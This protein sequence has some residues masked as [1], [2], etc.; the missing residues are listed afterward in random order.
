MKLG[1]QQSQAKD[2]ILSWY[3]NP[4]SKPAFY[5]G[6]WAGTGKTSIAQP[7]AE[8]LAGS[9]VVYAAYTGKAAYVLQEKGCFSAGTM[10]SVIYHSG[11]ASEK[12]VKELREK[13][14]AEAVKLLSDGYDEAALD[15]HPRL[16]LLDGEIALE[17]KNARR[18]IFSLNPDSKL[19]LAKLAVIDEVS[20]VNEKMA[21]DW[22]SFGVKTLV[23]GDP[24][25]LPPVAGEGFFTRHQPNF[26]LTEIHR[27]AEGNPIIF[28]STL[29][30]QSERPS[31]GSYGTSRVLKRGSVT[32]TELADMILKS[33]QVI[34]GENKTRHRF[35]NRIRELKGFLTSDPDSKWPQ[36]GERVVCLKNNHE[37]GLL[38]GA[39]YDVVR[40]IEA[41]PE[42]DRLEMTVKP[43]GGGSPI[44]VHC[45]THHFLGDEETLNKQWYS[46]KEAQEFDFGYALTCH[47][48]QGSQFEN[49]LIWDE[50]Y[51]ARGD[52]MKWL[53]TATTRAVKSVTLLL[54]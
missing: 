43:V 30:R 5:L 6:G 17:E 21:K 20:M 31:F 47:K 25:Q 11:E 24:F 9:A 26:M 2:S 34:V 23:L 12:K 39:L 53:Y 38:N 41:Y 28:L 49:P 51:V 15:L 52:R 13:R 48:S 32:K 4:D 37:L 16:S 10:H 7:I 50:S 42:I 54:Q 3:R 1:A 45:H 29:I 22:L 36:A 14:A 33:D 46:K 8:E 19:K 27:Q 18:P 35:N 44:D 40:L